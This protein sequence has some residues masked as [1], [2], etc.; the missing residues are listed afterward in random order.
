VAYRQR[1]DL[2]VTA[3]KKLVGGNNKRTAGF[4]RQTRKGRID[5]VIAT[6]AKDFNLQP[7]GQ[8]PPASL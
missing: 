6:S 1:D 5:L 8:P 3:G 7:D 4:L 2:R